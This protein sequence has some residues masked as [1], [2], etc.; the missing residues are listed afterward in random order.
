[1]KRSLYAGV[2]AVALTPA[3]TSAKTCVNVPIT[4]TGAI[5]PPTIN[6]EMMQV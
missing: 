6:V 2:A 5:V 4:D 3:M 1:M